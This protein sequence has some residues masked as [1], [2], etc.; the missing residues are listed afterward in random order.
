VYVFVVDLIIVIG[1]GRLIAYFFDFQLVLFDFLIDPSGE[2]AVFFQTDFGNGI[3]DDRDVAA[4]EDADHECTEEASADQS[5]SVARRLSDGS[6]VV[7]HT[8]SL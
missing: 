4:P 8:R 6:K 5:E 7:F 3:D 1:G 2:G